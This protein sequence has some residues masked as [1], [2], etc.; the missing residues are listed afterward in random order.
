MEFMIIKTPTDCKSCLE[1]MS[2]EDN[3][4]LFKCLKCNK[5]HK[6]FNE[7][8]IKILIFGST[9]E[10]CDEDINKLILLLRKGI[11]HY[12]YMHAKKVFKTFN[13]KNIGDYHHLYV[14][15][16]ILLLA[17]VFK[18]FRKKCIKIYETD[19]AH[20][21]CTWISMASLFKMSEIK[22]D[23]LLTVEKEIKGIKGGIYHAIHRHAE[24]NYKYM[25][26]YDK[27]K[28]SSYIQ[29]LDVNN[30]YGCAMSR[31]LPVDGFKWIKVA[32][33]IDKKLNRFI[34]LMKIFYEE[35]DDGY[36]LEVDV[37]YRKDLH[38]FHSDLPVLPERMKI[39]KCNIIVCNLYGKNNYVIHIKSLKQALNNGLI[40]KKVHRGIQFYEKTGFKKYF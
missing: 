6:E 4:L 38:D 20:F 32:S 25:K 28:E 15:S 1:N 18:I 19:P 3:Q 16:D 24:A 35:S 34:K 13:N 10:F 22:N 9:Y 26:N 29:Y 27:N 37:E 8:L 36:I 5:N 21:I 31:K 7:D 11:Y 40:L 23:M 12:E 39:K 33:S 2:A 14:Q 17:D 30:L